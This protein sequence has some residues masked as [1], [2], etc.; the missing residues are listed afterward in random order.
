MDYALK[1]RIGNPGLFTGRKKE[2]TYFLK[3]IDDIK[4]EKSQSVAL[5]A[6]RKMGKS[7]L[8][9][10]LFNITF[11]KND[12]VIPL[13]YE[14]KETKMWMG[15]FCVDFFVT[16]VYQYIAF[17]TR[18]TQYLK[19]IDTNNFEKIKSITQHEGFEDLTH[20]V[21]SVEYAFSHGNLDL[22][23]NTVRE[24]P[25]TIAGRKNEFIVQ[26]IDEFQFLNA[27]FYRDKDMKIPAD[28]LAGGYLSTAENKIAPLLVSGSWVGWLMN[29][30]QM[31]LPARFKYKPLKNMP[32]DEAVEMVFKY[33]QFFNVPVTEETAYLIAEFSEGSPFYI[34]S[35]IRSEFEAKDLTTVKGLS[36]TLEFETLDDQGLIKSTWMEYV[37]KSF[38]KV[39][40]RNAKRIVLHLFKYKDRELTRKELM[41]NLNLDMNDE[42]L[43]KKLEAL[44]KG[45]IIEQGQSN[46][47][48][49]SVRDN[50]FDKVFRGVYQK[51]IEQFNVKDI[52][53][54]YEE[55]LEKLKRQYRKLQGKYHSQKG[56]FAEYLILDQLKYRSR[57]NNNMLK[58]ITCNLPGDFEFREYSRVWR[59]DSS[60]EFSRSFSV[61][62][63]ARAAQIGDY[64]I[65]GEVKSRDA[66]KFSKEE[67][68]HFER[69]MIEVKK[70]EKIN[71]TVGFI[72][73]RCGFTAEAKEYFREKGIA[74]SEDVRWL[75]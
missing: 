17:K 32:K 20:M 36:K 75:E 72:F 58:S 57:K 24:A 64:S 33:S 2:L 31:M 34:R 42:T 41:D 25:K 71:R 22:L 52:S 44:V 10:R 55:S 59:Y 30:L 9:E 7:A 5:L 27:M 53:K 12:G 8:M 73:S 38:D 11:N 67:A 65:I 37:K 70:Q 56:Y 63:F 50:I 48:Y 74:Y 46:F 39:N 66:K 19:P 40:D 69:K 51:E 45:D 54:E 14:I 29:L 43:E 49:R 13:Y 23:W 68:V 21:E 61:D 16:F 35:M 28:D 6:R 1:E 60:P 15:D 62:I 26:M 4:E 3:W 47:D 18:N